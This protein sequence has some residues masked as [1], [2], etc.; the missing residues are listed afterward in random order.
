MQ[1]KI[2]LEEHFGL[3]ETFTDTKRYPNVAQAE[4]LRR[5]LLDIQDT[6]L[7]EMD[8]YGIEIGIQSL[9]SP[10]VQAALDPVVAVEMAK[11]AN[12]V[13]AE[14]VAKRPDRFR[15]FAAL[16]MQDP[17]AAI[18]EL[19]RCVNDLGFVG[20]NLNGFSQRGDADTQLF[21]DVR[22]FRPFWA[23]VE[24]LD[25]PVYLHPRNTLP[26]Q[27]RCY[28]GH[29]WFEHSGW[30]FAVETAIHT[31][32]LLASGLFDEHPKLQLIVGHLGERIP[33]DLWRVDHRI[34]KSP[35]GIPAKKTM[36]DYFRENVHLTTAGNFH[37]ETLHFTIRRV[38]IERLLFSVDYPFETT[39][40][41]CVWFDNADL[42]EADRRQIGRNN[43]VKLFKQNP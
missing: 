1:G 41:G 15:G 4:D 39:E 38:G 17:E 19:R 23:A 9:N 14:E 7:G 34:S 18:S 3:E 2:V 43:A 30:A 26:S 28:E 36:T 37:D 12:D 24:E 6:R 16:P 20:A 29:P 8:Q 5:R 25:V 22:E 13:L 35:Q 11:H 10:G 27:G 31:L 21:Y 42:S 33:F 32:R 40:E